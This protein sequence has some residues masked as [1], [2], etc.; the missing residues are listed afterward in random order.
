MAH[1][2]RLEHSG[3]APLRSPSPGCRPPSQ[4]GGRLDDDWDE[5]V[6]AV[7]PL[8]REYERAGDR[9]AASPKGGG[10]LRQKLVPVRGP[11]LASLGPPQD[12]D[13]CG[14]DASRARHVLD[15]GLQRLQV[16]QGRRAFEPLYEYREAR[17]PDVQEAPQGRG[18]LTHVRIERV[19]EAALA[20]EQR[21]RRD[22][23][24]N[25]HDAAKVVARVPQIRED[26]M[27]SV[28]S[29]RDVDDRIRRTDTLNHAMAQRE[30]I[31]ERPQVPHQLEDREAEDEEGDEGNPHEDEAAERQ[32][33][34]GS[35]DD[36]K[37]QQ[38]EPSGRTSHGA[39]GQEEDHN[40][41]EQEEREAGEALAQRGS[42]DDQEEVEEEPD[43][44]EPPHV[45][46][47]LPDFGRLS[48]HGLR[49][50]ENRGDRI[51]DGPCVPSR[52]FAV[53]G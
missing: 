36:D 21:R 4:A 42:D 14:W 6:R 12:K 25:R 34:E 40:W 23:A 31:E 16:S 44:H 7:I 1:G 48:V 30:V 9:R 5:V 50:I 8:D 49:E 15:R 3:G 22:R 28:L 27:D 38:D 35:E 46:E 39:H 11:A 19:R 20:R 24:G 32:D 45:P 52:S 13:S 26:S 41:D 43:G 2:I 51:F 18:R 33:L 17:G 29:L 10:L 37:D 47:R 53:H